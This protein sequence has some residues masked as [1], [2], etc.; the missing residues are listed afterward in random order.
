MKEEQLSPPVIP[1]VLSASSFQPPLPANAASHLSRQFNCNRSSNSGSPSPTSSSV[2]S[3]STSVGG[4]GGVPIPAQLTRLN[5]PVHI[6]VGGKAFT[7][8]LETLTKYPN[9]KLAKMFSG[10]IPIVLDSLKQ[11]YFVDRDG[12][13][14]RH[15]L[16]FLRN[17]SI[18]V[19]KDPEEINDL[20]QEA[21]FYEMEDLENKLMELL[22]ATENIP[23]TEPESKNQVHD[24]VILDGHFNLELSDP[25]S[26][27][28]SDD[29]FVSGK[30]KT[31][32]KILNCNT[33]DMEKYTNA[34][35]CTMVPKKIFVPSEN[36]NS[37][38]DVDKDLK[39]IQV[40]Q[41]FLENGYV[42]EN[43]SLQYNGS[44]KFAQFVLKYP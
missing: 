37:D 4:G 32:Q 34:S 43:S 24:L 29:W 15:V 35:Y 7:T 19:K 23:K 26:F 36:D 1:T 38:D 18:N 10:K 31:I 16:N 6:D 39:V 17:G 5:A 41:M 2:V 9:S 33:E 25:D 21:R 12:H 40:L 11:H 20:L 22:I 44:K 30:S 42:M 14:F 13:L 3:Q 27:T 28:G 8:T